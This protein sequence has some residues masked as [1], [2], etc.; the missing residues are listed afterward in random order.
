MARILLLTAFPE[1][2]PRP[3]GGYL[4]LKR[5]ALID[6]LKVHQLVED[7]AEADLIL[8]AEVDVG[9][10]CEEVLR[11]PYVARFRE[12][13]FMMSTDYRALPFLPGIYTGLEKK[14]HHPG[15]THPGFYFDCLVNPLITFDSTTE[16]DLLYSFMGDTKTHPVR[17]VLAKLQHPRGLFVDTSGESQAVM[18]RGTDEEK[19]VFWDRYAKIARR[20]K[21]IFCP[22]GVA[23]SSIRL[24]ETMCLGRVAIVVADEWVRPEGPDWDSCIIQIPERDAASIVSMV[25]EKE[26]QAAE[27]G[28][29]ARAEWEKHFAPDIVFH[30]AVE[31]CLQMQRRRHIPE[32]LARFSLIPQL[33]QPYVIREYLRKCKNELVR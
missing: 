15:R 26:A 23:P 18:W 14:W 3:R 17:R 10:F 11:H 6:R 2:N 24:F 4:S 19:T 30:R 13:C 7:P 33:L 32:S 21:F 8:F 31:A 5:N 29:R 27:M 1:S 28:L 22:R 16:R 20:S 25:E 9:R 12:K